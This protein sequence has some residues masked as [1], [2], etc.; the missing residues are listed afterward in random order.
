MGKGKESQR[1]GYG[2]GI[3]DDMWSFPDGPREERCGAMHVCLMREELC[4]ERC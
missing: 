2:A 1:E 3:R 4:V